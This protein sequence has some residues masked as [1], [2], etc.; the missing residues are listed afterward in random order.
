MNLTTGIFMIFRGLKYESNEELGES[1][2]L[3]TDIL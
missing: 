3:L 2:H 1:R